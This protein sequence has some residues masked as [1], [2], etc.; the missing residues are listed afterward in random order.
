MFPH[1]NL[2]RVVLLL[3]LVGG[4]AWVLWIH[5]QMI[6]AKQI[7]NWAI[8]QAYVG[9]LES[10]HQTYGEFPLRLADA[11][12]DT[13]AKRAAWL[14]SHDAYGNPLHYTSDGRQFLIASY[15]RDG[16][17]DDGP[18]ARD[19]GEFSRTDA[20]CRDLDTD[21]AYSSDG[22]VQRCGK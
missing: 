9:F 11:V 21:T 4:A 17:R 7:R 6:A 1:V 12:P 3:V 8:V 15:G 2:Y 22:V 18:Y 5:P 16:I 14:S 10:H 19:V 13:V 20:P